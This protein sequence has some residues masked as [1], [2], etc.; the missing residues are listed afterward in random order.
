MPAAENLSADPGLINRQ[1]QSARQQAQRRSRSKTRDFLTRIENATHMAESSSKI[2]LRLQV[3]LHCAPASITLPWLSFAIGENQLFPVPNVEQ[4]AEAISR[5]L[6]LELDK[7]FTLSP[8]QHKFLAEDMP[9]IKMLQ[10]SFEN[11]YKAVF[12]TSHASSRDRFFTLNATRFAAFLLMAD[13]LPDSGWHFIKDTTRQPIKIRQSNLPVSLFLSTE[14]DPVMAGISSYRL[15][16]RCEQNMQQMTASRNI[17][18][19]GDQFYLPSHES[20]RLIEPIDH[21]RRRKLDVPPE[22]D[23][24]QKSAQHRPQVDAADPVRPQHRV[25]RPR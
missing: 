14:T 13:S 5:D 22:T 20:I 8:L 16:F 17:Y 25:P 24:K 3:T 15:E 12:G 2:P 6:P 11:D 4:F 7:N 23:R 19:V 10:D 18:L 1:Q 9:L 21:P